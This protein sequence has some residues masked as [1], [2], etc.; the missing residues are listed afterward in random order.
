MGERGGII[1]NQDFFPTLQG[2]PVE[3]QE[4]VIR[5]IAYAKWEQLRHP[6]RWNV[7]L[8]AED[9]EALDSHPHLS[10]LT[11]KFPETIRGEVKDF[12]ARALRAG[13]NFD[14]T[15]PTR[16]APD[17]II[18]IEDYLRRNKPSGG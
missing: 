5:E 16:R 14:P 12:F 6:N 1:E 7:P 13:V 4:I 3:K 11:A 15:N 18:H 8:S 17:N 9:I 2:L 10:A